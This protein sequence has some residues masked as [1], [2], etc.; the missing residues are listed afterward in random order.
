MKKFMKS[1][2]K[3]SVLLGGFAACLARGGA[4]DTGIV[5]DA[6]AVKQA[7]AQDVYAATSQGADV[8]VMTHTIR[9]SGDSRFNVRTKRVYSYGSGYDMEGWG[10]IHTG[11]GWTYSLTESESKNGMV[12]V[13]KPYYP[14]ESGSV[15]E[16]VLNIC[17]NS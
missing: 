9:W 4:F 11:R 15:M 8:Y 14:V 12:P 1:V 16:A 2:M 13:S 3:K 5:P 10:F 7:H 17:L 6:L